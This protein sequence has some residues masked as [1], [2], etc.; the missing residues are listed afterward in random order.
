MCRFSTSASRTNT[1]MRETT[2]TGENRQGVLNSI[3]TANPIWPTRTLYWSGRPACGTNVFSCLILSLKLS[4]IE[5]NRLHWNHAGEI[6]VIYFPAQTSFD[7]DWY[8]NRILQGGPTIVEARTVVHFPMEISQS[9][10]SS[11]GSCMCGEI[12]QQNCKTS[13]S[14]LFIFVYLSISTH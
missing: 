9:I 6:A 2:E 3:M 4:T 1:Q 12:D 8:Q 10:W 13:H 7:F 5:M 14:G 11:E